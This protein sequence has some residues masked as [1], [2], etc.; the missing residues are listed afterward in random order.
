MLSLCKDVGSEDDVQLLQVVNQ[1]E[2]EK[3][4]NNVMCIMIHVY[5]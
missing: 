2:D 5:M 4:G 3:S 1:A